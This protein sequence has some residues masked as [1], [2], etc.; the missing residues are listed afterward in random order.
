LGVVVVV[1]VVGGRRLY[2]CST[3]D[4]SS[5]ILG[6]SPAIEVVRS[7]LASL[8]PRL[9]ASAALP[10]ILLHGET[11]TG[12]GLLARTIHRL[13][14]RR[15]RPFV[16]VNCPAIQPTLVE[17]EL[18]G[19]EQGAFTDARR[20]K[21]G[22]LQ[23]ANGGTVFLDEIG[24]IPEGVQAKLLKVL[25]ERTVR[26]VGSTRA[27]P[28]DVWV[29][30]ATND[31][32][33]AAVRERRFR[34]DLYHRL[35]VLPIALPPL[36]ERGEDVL[37]LAK[38]FLA[39][40][41][42]DYSLAA[43]TF[44]ADACAALLAYRWPGNVRELGNVVETAALLSSE[45]VITASMLDL[46]VVPAAMAPRA[47]LGTGR[48]ARVERAVPATEPPPGVDERE[49][50]VHA[51][52]QEGWNVSRAAAR[53]G[54]T[55]NAIRYRIEKHG[56]T[57]GVERAPALDPA[58]APSVTPVAPAPAPRAPGIRWERRRLAL[59]RVRV[60]DGEAAAA[61]LT[62]R[63]LE[64]AVD[65][66]QSFGGRV[67]ELSP[68]AALG[69]FGLDPT[70]DAP[71]RAAHAALA[72]LK[73][74][75]RAQRAG[76]VDVVAVTA[77][78]HVGLTLVTRVG[79]AMEIDAASRRETATLLDGLDAGAR[80]GEIVVSTA[81][82]RFLER[83]FELQPVEGTDIGRARLVAH[84]RGEPTD[85]DHGGGFVG[86]EHELGMLADAFAAADGGRGQLIGITGE[87]GIGK[88]R[89]VLELWRRL[90]DRPVVLLEGRCL[91]YTTAVPY[92][93]LVDV[94]RSIF[95]IG[96]GDATESLHAKVSARLR[97]LGL[98]AESSASALVRL[99]AGSVGGSAGWD[100]PDA[101]KSATFEIIRR[102][103]VAL[104]QRSPVLLLIEDMHWIDAT[105]A[106]L[107]GSF[108]DIVSGAR[109]V[110][111]ETYRPGYRPAWLERSYATQ[112][113]LQ[114]LS[115]LESRRLVET[116]LPPGWSNDAVLDR[117]LTRGDGN[118]FFLE[119][120]ARAVD[121][122]GDGHV[123]ET[124]HDLLL[125]RIDRLAPDDKLVLQTAAVI[126][127]DVPV[128]LLD[129]V[130]SVPDD[131]RRAALGRLRA[132]EF[133]HETSNA[134][135]PGYTFR[136]ALIHEVA[137][138]SLPEPVRRT[139]HGA[140][141]DAIER[142]HPTRLL[143]QA[144][145]LG[146]HTL[147]AEQ[148][149]RAVTYL[150]Q[151]GGKALATSAHRDAVHWFEQAT[152]A[153]ERLPVTD[154]TREIAID[155]HLA[156][157]SALLPLGEFGRMLERLRAAERL[158]IG[159]Q[160]GRRLGRVCAYLTDYF[161]QVGDHEQAL[162]TGRRALAAAELEDDL[163]ILVA[164]NIYLGHVYYDTGQY[165]RASAHFGRNVDAV[166]PDAVHERFGLPYL[167]SVHSRTWL[168]ATLAELGRF[169][170]AIA[171]GTDALRIAEG[172][173]HAS[174]LVSA[175]MGLGRAYLRQGELA[176]ATPV[177]ERGVELAR[178]WKMRLLL[179]FLTDSLGLAYALA[180]RIDDGL[181]LLREALELHTAMRGT[182]SQSARLISVAQGELLAGR[183]TEAHA[184]ATQALQLATK[185][186][187]RGY[188]AYAH[189]TLAEA[190]GAVVP[191]DAQRAESHW[192]R[193]AA[194]AAE[195][196]MRPLA[197]RCDLGLGALYAVSRRTEATARLEQARRLLREL[198]MPLWLARAEAELARRA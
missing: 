33:Q 7:K 188:E 102:L 153:V 161:R 77:S 94:L 155:L 191:L 159:L 128:S 142:L 107:L 45:P 15:S 4:L 41:C 24:L 54:L 18:F 5:E 115:A 61:S 127:R 143:E 109:I 87:A 62:S 27:E 75:Q 74:L 136:H 195:L 99:I 139:L 93:P 160:D 17:S 179:P 48:P 60:V 31:D 147:R 186:G 8:L 131:A 26:R 177:L 44:S 25:E 46:P 89:L 173:N 50:L 125:A 100:S 140:V 171:N 134:G 162:E 113:A 40:A 138:D 73:A 129:A 122:G 190:L 141:A 13:S 42:R 68:A 12:K 66:I 37:L 189:A 180:G 130:A 167:V 198:R 76:A 71:R 11:G 69:V 58:P 133:V 21:E 166:G 124:V 32:L 118:P 51:L 92:F 43:K 196:E 172:A 64:V 164:T 59:L 104:A 14:A 6:Q 9:S 137:Y 95:D 103:L 184:L 114:P 82:A 123:P 49:R 163:G 20:A 35:A 55:R 183:P 106:E 157:R 97:Q 90:G 81:A 152:G 47:P 67:D 10:S 36:R 108:A 65:K 176:R 19:F 85:R 88:S 182:A 193:A 192:H 135:E 96:E 145:R 112:I 117:I 146:E 185:R 72:I 148:W 52:E 101:L 111:I 53:L 38:Q 23:S 194:L 187:E 1:V 83:G 181:P 63:A 34:Q 170:D 132:A 3:M 154:E 178:R 80:A 151:A 29:I 168:A 78:V 156:A 70:E 169:A 119:E 175:H 28:L 144:E 149:T 150:R 57:P 16:D 165:G 197:A 116:A 22:L 91:A 2:G 79:D 174:S 126:G 110:L 120:L 30:A 56:L 105:S 39:R 98:D 158:A 86:R 84:E 121:D